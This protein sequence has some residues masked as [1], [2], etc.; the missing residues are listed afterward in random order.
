MI[1]TDPTPRV[2]NPTSINY[3]LRR[4]PLKNMNFSINP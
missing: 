4:N 2:A 3:I 1:P